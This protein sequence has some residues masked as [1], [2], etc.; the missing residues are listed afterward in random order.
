MS[1]ENSDEHWSILKDRMTKFP[2]YFS[3]DG[4]LNQSQ[5]YSDYSDYLS[6]DSDIK[7]KINSISSLMDTFNK[8]KVKKPDMPLSL[9]SSVEN[10]LN[11]ELK[12]LSL[13]VL[14]FLEEK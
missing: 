11:Q 12:L 13:S 2:K 8:V 9:I 3:K 14:I 5:F 7:D 4:E 6:L 1:K 10:R